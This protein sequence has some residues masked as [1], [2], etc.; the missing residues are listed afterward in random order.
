MKKILTLLFFATLTVSFAEA[1]YSDNRNQ[2]GNGTYNNNGQ[3]DNN[4]NN[5]YQNSSLIVNAYTQNGYTVTIDNG[6]KYQSNG[7]AL[8]VGS[9]TP[10]NHTVKVAEYSSSVLGKLIPKVIYNSTIYFKQNVQTTL[11]IDN[12]RQVNITERQLN[13]NGSYGN[14]GGNG[15]GNKYKKN[16][17]PHDNRNGEKHEHGNG[18]GHGHNEDN[19]RND[20]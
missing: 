11:N 15:R 17:Y 9:L 6:N 1:Q 2:N 3:Y 12:N 14:N 10:G 19:D 20:D 7:A 18:R 16:K 8:N 13:G 4:Q 5:S